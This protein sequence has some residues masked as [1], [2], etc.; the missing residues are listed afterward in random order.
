MPHHLSS[1]FKSVGSVTENAW[2]SATNNLSNSPKRNRERGLTLRQSFQQ[3]QQ[4]Q[5][6]QQVQ[7]AQQVQQIQPRRLFP[8]VR[9]A[10]VPTTATATADQ[11]IGLGL[12]LGMEVGLE[13]ADHEHEQVGIP[14]GVENQNPNT[15]SAAMVDTIHT[16]HTNTSNKITSNTTFPPLSTS[17]LTKTSSKNTQRSA[18]SKETST[19]KSGNSYNPLV[20]TSSTYTNPSE[21]LP[22]TPNLRAVEV[23]RFGDVV[24]GGTAAIGGGDD[25][26]GGSAG[27]SASHSQ[28]EE[29]S[30]VDGMGM[31]GPVPNPIPGSAFVSSGSAGSGAASA[32]GNATIAHE[33]S[34]R[35]GSI[36]MQTPIVTASGTRVHNYRGVDHGAVVIPGSASASASGSGINTP[37]L[38]A[39]GIGASGLATQG[40]ERAFTIPRK[41]VPM[42]IVVGNTGLEVV[43]Y[44]RPIED[45]GT[46]ACIVNRQECMDWKNQFEGTGRGLG[47]DGDEKDGEGGEGEEVGESE[48]ERKER[49]E[50]ERKEREKRDLLHENPLLSHPVK[51]TTIATGTPPT[52][53]PT[54]IASTSLSS[55]RRGFRRSW[56]APIN[57]FNFTSLGGIGVMGFGNSNQDPNMHGGLGD[58]GMGT[59]M[60][61]NQRGT[62]R[63]RYSGNSSEAMGMG[64]RR[65]SFLR[66]ASVSFKGMGLGMQGFLRG[67]SGGGGALAGA[68]AGT[69]A[70]ERMGMSMDHTREGGAA[71]GSGRPVTM[72]SEYRGVGGYVG[73]D[74]MALAR[75]RV[76]EAEAQRR[77]SHRQSM[78]LPKFEWEEEFAT[79]EEDEGNA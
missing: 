75:E 45:I 9:P 64:S 3:A 22:P 77:R 41:P 13:S 14:S 72:Q 37:R 48:E 16:T 27:G 57:G 70:A 71:A 53:S 52:V 11:P 66:R 78:V 73:D 58:T 39:A 2:E 69:A 26:A 34:E 55:K 24:G 32:G 7:Q 47:Q 76:A 35:H 30:P 74:A 44:G 17:A 46:G 28:S 42:T 33:R 15:S 54:Y 59:G 56:T 60:G 67:T 12:G 79:A 19:S 36:N 4:T 25:S 21:N 65:G 18:N 63:D 38:I 62:A 50:K 8:A 51:P 31:F 10:P 6:T 40:R 29:I 49:L 23:G 68:G 20:T 1:F 43:P 61:I 5:Q